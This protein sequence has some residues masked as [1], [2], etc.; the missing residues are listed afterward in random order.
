MYNNNN[1]NQKGQKFGGKGDQGYELK[2]QVMGQWGSQGGQLLCQGHEL[3]CT[4]N[5]K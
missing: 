4:I 3:Q 1:N 2:V 5:I